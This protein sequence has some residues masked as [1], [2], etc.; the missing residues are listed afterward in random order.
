MNSK[1]KNIERKNVGRH[2]E[3]NPP[4]LIFKKNIFIIFIIFINL[5]ACIYKN[6]RIKIINKFK[7][8]YI[9]I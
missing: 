5:Y 8:I 2:Q 6:M 1:I 4:P 7:Y 9:N 3:G